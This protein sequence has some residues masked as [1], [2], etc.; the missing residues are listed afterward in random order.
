MIVIEDEPAVRAGGAP[1]T[2]LPDPATDL[3]SSPQRSPQRK[4]V[5]YFPLLGVRGGS[6]FADVLFVDLC[7]SRADTSGAPGDRP[8][9]AICFNHAAKGKFPG[10]GL[11]GKGEVST[12]GE[13]S[14]EG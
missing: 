3:Q 5:V 8:R 9:R 2:N 11:R 4:C 7:R 6:T 1:E 12:K 13:F 10:K 14:S